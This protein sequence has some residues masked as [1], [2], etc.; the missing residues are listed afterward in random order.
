MLEQLRK[1]GA[2]VAIYLI[3]GLLIIIFVINF[4]PNAGSG[5]GGGCSP[6]G[7]VM[8][9]G[10]AKL[11][12]SAY[13]VA[14][15]ANKYS[16]RQKVYAALEMMIRRE[17]LAD[18]ASAAGIRVTK[19]AVEAEMK[20]GYF[21]YAG[22]R[23]P[24]YQVEPMGGPQFV[25]EHSFFDVVDG[26]HFFNFGKFK[27]WVNSLNVSIG[28][29]YDE[30][31]RAMQ[32]ALY[33]E[34]LQES[35]RV[36]RDEALSDYL[37]ASNTVSYDTVTFDPSAYRDAMRLA[38]A[39]VT[40][41]LGGHEADVKK[42]YT[43]EERT[44]KGTKPALKL[45]QIKID[46]DPAEPKPAEKPADPAK[47]ADPT[48]PADPKPADAKPADAKP[49]DVKPADVK[50]ADPK[51]A[52]PK[53][54]AEKAEPKKP[55]TAEAKAK[56][57]TART[58]IAANKQKFADA[59]KA[60]STDD[61]TKWNGGDVGWK[62][63]DNAGLGDKAVNDAVKALKPGEMTA[64]VVGENAVYLVM[65]EDKRE[66][67]LTFDQVKGE[68]AAEMAR[69]VWSKE[70]AKRAALDAF[71][72]AHAGTAKNLSDLF[73]RGVNQREQQRQMQEL[74]E[75]QM[76]QQQHGSLD[77]PEKDHLAS[78]QASDDKA[79]AGTAGAAP[80]AAGTGS[81]A[82]TPAAGSAAPATGS[83]APATGTGSGAGAPTSPPPAPAPVELKASTDVLPAFGEIKKPKVVAE[84]KVQRQKD[85]PG[86]ET[87][88]D[89]STA[90]FDELQPG[91]LG[92]KVYETPEG[93]V[94]LQ[95]IDKQAPKVEDFDK[96]ADQEIARLRSIRG[97]M[98]VEG[99]LKT[100]CEALKKDGKIKPVADLVHETDDAG[101][102]LPQVYQPC[103][104]FR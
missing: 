64:V 26:D 19:D 45:R 85:M 74:I 77:Q 30:Q 17:L 33:S 11:N 21:F 59:A 68:I 100:R 61:A 27:G 4:A 83:A 93:F 98:A 3:F 70:A 87:V 49:A 97:R 53:K 9:V 90:L 88:T 48:K 44:Y 22:F 52:D 39:D 20:K 31:A 78:W 32:A 8:T 37:F 38:D 75:Q 51:P 92:K 28:S 95:L 96:I 73:E 63:L 66:G 102:P 82:P 58:A 86:L 101:K 13:H 42:K 104:S 16:G 99:W 5:Q 65:A 81:A 34:L 12:Q 71:S 23:I 41:F 69:D 67:D 15:A 46:T 60:L 54:P 1:S 76:Q 7:A 18:G 91:M 72:A 50:P 25:S 79:P 40:R 84:T 2:S 47:P 10:S 43:D 89:A 6:G 103:M 94:L 24:D 55:T 35:V 14:Y 80:P 36:S 57:E 62:Q 56:L 29:Y